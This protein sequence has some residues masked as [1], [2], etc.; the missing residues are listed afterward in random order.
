M[1]DLGELR[2]RFALPFA[3][4][5]GPGAVHLVAGEDLRY[6]L[7]APALEAWLPDLLAGLDG[8]RRVGELVAGLTA[9]RR[10]EAFE[11]IERLVAE[12]VL[13]RADVAASHVP[14]RRSIAV[15]GRGP[16][17]AAL[18]RITREKAGSASPPI[19]VL[20]QDDLDYGALL[21][22]NAECLRGGAPF[23]WVSSGP[24]ARG[25]VSPLCL[26]DAG[27][28]LACLVTSFRRLSPAPEIYDA[29]EASSARGER[30]P[31]AD[32]P[33]RCGAILAELAAF[34]LEL[35][36][37]PSPSAA[38]YALHVL[39]LSTLELSSHRPLLDP[40]CPACAELR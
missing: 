18:E 34:K 28:C 27:P 23:L 14:E 4:L 2:L 15:E 7:E 20:C 12:R 1:R 29:L 30:L 40:E 6:A 25:F 26:P 5:P 8:R 32:F 10:A 38:L 16:I 39:E 31:V 13:V 11:I 3:V 37:E 22:F 24:V 17:R 9:A 19:R 36:S 33:P 21:A 35:A